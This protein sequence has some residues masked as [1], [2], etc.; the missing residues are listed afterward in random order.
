L[1]SA[2]ERREFKERM[3]TTAELIAVLSEAEEAEQ[4][5]GARRGRGHSAADT[6]TWRGVVPAQRGRSTSMPETGERRPPKLSKGSA[7]RGW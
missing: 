3:V 2:R 7:R 1:R 6:P 5:S 4:A